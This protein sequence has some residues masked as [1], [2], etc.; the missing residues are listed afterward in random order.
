M[1]WIDIGFPKEC[2]I[3]CID[4]SS[5]GWALACSGS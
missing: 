3:K 4:L 2:S 1:Q 5:D